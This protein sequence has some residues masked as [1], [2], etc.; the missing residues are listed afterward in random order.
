MN[1]RRR[2]IA[3]VINNIDFEDNKHKKRE[4]AEL[5]SE[6]LERVLSRLHFEI[7]LFTDQ[8]RDE[9]ENLLKEESTKNHSDADCF[10]CVIMSH[11]TKLADGSLGVFGV[12]GEMINILNEAKTIFSNQNCL[13]LK[14]KPKL[15]FIDACW[16]EKQ[17]GT[18]NT[19]LQNNT[20]GCNMINNIQTNRADN[21]NNSYTTSI[22]NNQEISDFLLSFSTLPNFV[23]N[24][25]PKRGNWFIQEF[26]SALSEFGETRTLIDIMHTVRLKLMRKTTIFVAQLSVDHWMLSRH[27]I[28]KS[29]EK[30]IL[31]SSKLNTYLLGV[32]EEEK[33]KV[34]NVSERRR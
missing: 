2:G 9:I 28:F 34:I 18:F 20:N 5:D 6:I 4:G 23:S 17:M 24:R 14:N 7:H 25:H 10:M 8:T 22:E 30:N 16:G 26:A 32:I 31:C 29:K 11:G 1:N 3:L 12:D 33:K 19:Y 15:F 21:G 13:S 27:V